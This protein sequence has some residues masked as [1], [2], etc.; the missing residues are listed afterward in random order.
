MSMTLAAAPV[1]ASMSSTML[2]LAVSVWHTHL[3]APA[4]LPASGAQEAWRL[5][6]MVGTTTDF[7]NGVCCRRQRP[8]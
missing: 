6:Q 7:C 1:L 2:G 4:C 3:V 5:A 8:V